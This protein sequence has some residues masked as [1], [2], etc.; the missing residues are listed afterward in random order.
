M[1]ML[2]R[3]LKE[4]VTFIVL[5][6]LDGAGTSTQCALLA[7]WLQELGHP[8]IATREPTEG[9]WGKQARHA[10]R[11]ETSLSPLSLAFTFMADR[12]Y[13]LADLRDRTVSGAIII[14]DRYFFS[15][16]AYQQTESSKSLEW[17]LKTVE[18]LPLP[19]LTVFLDVPPDVCVARMQQRSSQVER[20]EQ[21]AMLQRIDSAYRRVFSAYEQQ[22]YHI[23]N[24][25][26]QP[27]A[28]AVQAVLR[29]IVKDCVK[30]ISTR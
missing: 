28:D 2:K 14:S 6:G 9:P 22:D 16:L 24:I 17:F 21:L 8:V 18:P 19:D 26:G 11:G 15:Y 5:E 4:D 23:A 7:E 13:H 29:S 27:S 20:F 25:D 10:L 30:S 1:Q 12:A 3:R